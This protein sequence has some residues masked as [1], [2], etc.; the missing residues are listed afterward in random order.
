MNKAEYLSTAVE[1]GGS[2]LYP[3]STQG[4]TFIQDQIELLQHIARIGGGPT[5]TISKPYK[6]AI[7]GETHDGYLFNNGEVLPISYSTNQDK[8]KAIRIVETTEDIQA[9]GTKYK[10]AR[11][12]RR[13][14]YELKYVEGDNLSVADFPL[15]QTNTQLANKLADYAAINTE[16]AKKLTVFTSSSLTR[17][18]LDKQTDNVRICCRKGCVALN[19]AEE[20]TINVYKHS[21]SNITQEQL[22]P[23]GRR[24]VRYWNATAKMWGGFF[25]VT[26][27]L[28]IDVKV[29]NGSTVYIRH[30]YIPEGVQLVLL[31]KKKRSRKRRSGETNNIGLRQ[32]KNQWVHYKGIILSTSSPNTWYV[33]K[34]IR[35]SNSDNNNLIGKEFSSICRDLFTVLQ[36]PSKANAY[37]GVYK[38]AGTS[39]KISPKGWYKGSKGKA[40][41]RIALQFANAGTTYKSA[42]GEMA[43]MK[44]RLWFDQANS[45]TTER[46]T[47]SAD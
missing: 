10:E 4:L 3:L 26:E 36:V 47:F 42:G 31:R 45:K 46:R 7:T 24:Y 23:D 34:C 9:D 37:Q 14:V 30:G 39:V 6:D 25:P 29:V 33:P 38:I 27:N 28:H 12:Y 35:V 40:Y 43:T 41:V 1:N 16:L 17:V 13:C 18:Q 11:K 15:V 32:P 8:C 5:F 2:G 21:A 44:Y 22:L 19:G 20:Y